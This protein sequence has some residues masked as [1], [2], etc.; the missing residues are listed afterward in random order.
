GG[1]R[2][3]VAT[4]PQGRARIGGGTG[5]G[6]GGGGIRERRG[7]GLGG[8]GDQGV[9]RAGFW[10]DSGGGVG[11]G[12][13][14]GGLQKNQGPRGLGQTEQRRLG[15]VDVHIERRIVV[16]LL[17][18]RVNQARDSLH[19]LEHFVGVLARRGRVESRHLHVHRR[20]QAEVEDLADDVRRQERE[21]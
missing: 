6:R 8:L 2:R 12:G 21:G 10:G 7:G 9:L 20:G 18:A 1:W 16:G 15:T 17:D 5:S 3:G 19:A 11:V 4:L 14:R 13:G